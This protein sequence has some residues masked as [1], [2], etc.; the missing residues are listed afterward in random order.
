L[1]ADLQREVRADDV[2]LLN[3]NT[4]AEFF[5]NYYKRSAPTVYTLSPSPGERY[6]PE[7]AP[8]LISSH[9][10]ELIH[11]SS[12]LIIGALAEDHH[13]LWLVL[14][15]SRAV[16]WSVRPLE[17]YLARHAFPVREIAP[18]DLAR[19]VLFDLTAAPPPTFAAWPDQP[20]NATLGAS[21]RL[22][23]F[24]LPGQG[25]GTAGETLAVS[26]L[27]QALAPIPRDYTVA[28]LLMSPDGRLVAQRDSLPV[29][30][31][32]PMSTWAPGALIRDNHGVALPA[33]L[34]PGDYE[35]WLVV[36]WWQ[37]PAE[38]L[39]VTDSSGS[40]LGDH[41]VLATITVR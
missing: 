13:R 17:H 24:D 29:N 36:Y 39:P 40:S 35:L 34:S 18:S 19:A 4:Y 1:L 16:P 23:G 26:L 21:V 30:G 10:D 20:V 12:A 7:Q 37:T 22:V 5:M 27:W 28:L 3:T 2:I 33:D 32:A 11:Y 14:E 25:I 41:V 38:R 31:F 9:P 8:E 6:S 15:S